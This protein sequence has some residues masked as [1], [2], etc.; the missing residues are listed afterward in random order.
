M[1]DYNFLKG[2]AIE[3]ISVLLAIDNGIVCP[4]AQVESGSYDGPCLGEF[5]LFPAGATALSPLGHV[6]LPAITL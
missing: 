5:T 3:N 6:L 1:G 4:M 2:H